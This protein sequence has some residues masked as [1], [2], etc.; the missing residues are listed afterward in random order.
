MWRQLSQTQMHKY[1]RMD[2][3]THKHLY[4]YKRG[5]SSDHK[6]STKF[7]KVTINSRITFFTGQIHTLSHFS[8]ERNTEL[9]FQRDTVTAY[10]GQFIVHGSICILMNNNYPRPCPWIGACL[11]EQ[12]NSQEEFLMWCFFQC[13]TFYGGRKIVDICLFI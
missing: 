11:S 3:H 4:V 12:T 10:K 6:T 5:E 1:T 8:S 2:T 7:I 13:H 9:V